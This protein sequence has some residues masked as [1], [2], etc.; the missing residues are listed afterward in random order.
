MLVY[1]TADLTYS[2]GGVSRAFASSIT[3]SELQAAMNAVANMPPTVQAWSNGAAAVSYTVQQVPHPLTTVT[4]Y[5]GGYW[6]SP[7]NVHA[8]IDAYAPDGTYDSVLVLWK[9]WN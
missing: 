1:R 4:A 7:D 2:D 8:D 9:S 6:V 3:D 5:A